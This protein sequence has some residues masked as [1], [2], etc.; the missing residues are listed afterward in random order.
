MKIYVWTLLYV[1]LLVINLCLSNFEQIG[2]FCWKYHIL[3]PH[4][5]D[6]FYCIID[7]V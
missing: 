1:F 3:H 4:I 2:Y 6:I 7:Y 5:G